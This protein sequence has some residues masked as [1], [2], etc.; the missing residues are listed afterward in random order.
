MS[1]RI[2]IEL[3][4]LPGR[5]RINADLLYFD[6]SEELARSAIF[7]FFDIFNEKE[8]IDIIEDLIGNIEERISQV[9]GNKIRSL[10]DELKR[11]TSG[12]EKQEPGKAG[13]KK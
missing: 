4:T 8:K 11:L 7:D 12:W 13:E 9:E 5:L 10:R 2:T 3:R 1:D 6:V